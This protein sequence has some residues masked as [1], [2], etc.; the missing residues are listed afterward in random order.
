MGRLLFFSWYIFRIFIQI[1]IGFIKME[2]YTLPANKEI[3][4]CVRKITIFRSG[5]Y[6]SFRQKLTPSPYCC[7]TY[8]HYHI[9][10]FSINNEI[11]KS[12][13][14]LQVTGPK[15]RD[16]I[17]AL[18][19]GKLSQVLIE[20]TASGFYCFFR[21]TPADYLNTTVALT[22]LMDGSNTGMLSDDLAKT[23]DPNEHAA[24][25]Q[26]FI[27][28]MNI[29]KSH[30]YGYLVTAIRLIEESNG[31]ISVNTVCGQINISERQLNRKFIEITGSKAA[32]VY[33]IKTIALHH[34]PPSFRAIQFIERTCLSN[35][36]L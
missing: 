9:P 18:H 30:K 23:D 31:N 28:S 8:N 19:N 34:K 22:N 29:L 4:H 35:G 11:F 10:D 21:R 5:E 6:S 20:F 24:L 32:S 36:I 3:E 27:A 17:Y 14:R 1:K 25:I 13:H 2:I 26:Q 12:D 15:T 7:L 33:Q 16:D